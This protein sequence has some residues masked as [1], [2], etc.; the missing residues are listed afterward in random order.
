MSFRREFIDP[1][2]DRMRFDLEVDQQGVARDP[3]WLKPSVT[4]TV[5]RRNGTEDILPLAAVCGALFKATS[6][7]PR[8]SRLLCIVRYGP[9]PGRPGPLD[10]LP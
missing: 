1:A 4:L 10:I 8:L 2:Q 6:R 9:R 3:K 7:R 5:G